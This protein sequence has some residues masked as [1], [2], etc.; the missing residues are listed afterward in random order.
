MSNF[1]DFFEWITSL[2]SKTQKNKN[3]LMFEIYNLIDYKL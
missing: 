3:P 2:L 1:H